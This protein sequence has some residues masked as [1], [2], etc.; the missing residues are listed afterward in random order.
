MVERLAGS[1][2]VA[3]SNPARST[4]QEREVDVEAHSDETY[5]SELVSYSPWVHK[6]KKQLLTDLI[7]LR[8]KYYSVSI[9]S[10]KN[11]N[12]QISRLDIP[13][14]IFPSD[15]VRVI[16]GHIVYV[17]GS[18]PKAGDDIYLR[19]SEE[20]EFVTQRMLVDLGLTLKKRKSGL[21]A[22]DLGFEV[23]MSLENIKRDQLESLEVRQEAGVLQSR[24]NIFTDP[25]IAA[26]D[27]KPFEKV[28]ARMVV[29]LTASREARTDQQFV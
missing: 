1:Q 27:N 25:V 15:V 19:H 11:I 21:T 6:Y 4:S 8:Y 26:T 5:E 10:T 13:L 24:L 17:N 9:E 2:K 28:R 29:S 18:G 16:R 20:T 3:G 7:Q 14:R 12:N 22:A 23:Y